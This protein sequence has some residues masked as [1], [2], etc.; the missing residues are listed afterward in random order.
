MGINQTAIVSSSSKAIPSLGGGGTAASRG[1]TDLIHKTKSFSFH[2]AAWHSYLFETI[3]TSYTVCCFIKSKM[4]QLLLHS[5]HVSHRSQLRDRATLFSFAL[6]TSSFG[7]L[8]QSKKNRRKLWSSKR[9]T[10]R[11][12]ESLNGLTNVIHT[13]TQNLFT[14]PSKVFFIASFSF[15]RWRLCYLFFPPK[16]T[17]KL[18]DNW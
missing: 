5:S 13:A 15:R 6:K 2:S 1:L 12:H 14:R 3:K 11:S 16:K 8:T 7:G 17:L 18:D 10:R 4:T 9:K